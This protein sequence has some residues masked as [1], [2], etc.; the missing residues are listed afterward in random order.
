MTL[1]R[2]LAFALVPELAENLDY[3]SRSA[4]NVL[5]NSIELLSSSAHPLVYILFN[6]RA[7]KYMEK[8]MAFLMRKKIEESEN[9]DAI[10]ND[11]NSA[12]RAS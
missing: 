10:A 5:A 4:A 3:N 6:E 2:T 12:V 8:I 1:I 7:Y 9:A 11:A